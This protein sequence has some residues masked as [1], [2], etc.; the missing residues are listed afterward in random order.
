MSVKFVFNFILVG[1]LVLIFFISSPLLKSTKYF[2]FRISNQH[3]TCYLFSML[4]C[5]CYGVKD[6]KS[7]QALTPKQKHT[8][9]HDYNVSTFHAHSTSFCPLRFSSFFTNSHTI[10]V[11][12]ITYYKT[13]V[14][15]M[16][17]KICSSSYVQFY[18]PIVELYAND[19]K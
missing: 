12:S 10:H 17:H 11:E 8:P 2:K 3:G 7:T 4:F 16:V 18:F 9:A 19:T 13:I 14:R 6:F 15:T 5:C 1:I